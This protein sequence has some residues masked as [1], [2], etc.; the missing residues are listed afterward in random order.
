[1]VSSNEL[2]FGLPEQLPNPV[3]QD[4]DYA[5]LDAEIRIV[6][7]QRT[8]EIKSLMRRTAQDI[9]DIGQK[10]AEV[11]VEL[12]HGHFRHWLKSEFDWS[13]WTATKYMQVATKFKCVNFTHL[14]I[15]HSAL[16]ELAA[17]STSE[18]ARIEAIERANQGEK[19]T[20]SKAKVIKAKASTRQHKQVTKFQPDEP[21]TIDIDAE[22]V[23]QE[24]STGGK[25][26]EAPLSWQHW[27]D[28]SGAVENSEEDLLGED[29]DS[30][31][32]DSPEGEFHSKASHLRLVNNQDQLSDVE[33]DHSSPL[34][35]NKPLFTTSDS[36]DA[37]LLEQLEAV[38]DHQVAK[39][40]ANFEQRLGAGAFN[41]LVVE[42]LPKDDI[43]DLCN[44]C[45][46]S[47]NEQAFSRLA[48]DKINFSGLTQSALSLLIQKSQRE[49]DERQR[50]A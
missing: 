5:T 7:K 2:P 3:A 1:M 26:P 34:D 10:L 40:L 11:K 44:K 37:V 9:I 47:M 17:P 29:T 48:V 46:D 13:F 18:L 50:L 43:S 39:M 27:A 28:N 8:S 35:M 15:A 21:I 38:D 22:T 4:F 23:G 30:E 42:I 32:F 33:P 25:I 20:C 31:I 36:T 41:H 16:Y 24:S 6:V 49:M 19:I 45:L 14:D 12:G